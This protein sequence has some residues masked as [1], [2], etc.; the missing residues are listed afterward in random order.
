MAIQPSPTENLRKMMAIQPSPTENLKKMI[1][2]QEK[3]RYFGIDDYLNKQF[4]QSLKTSIATGEFFENETESDLL[5]EENNEFH[6][7]NSD[8][9]NIIT[10]E[11]ELDQNS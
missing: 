3:S 9:D 4:R 2:Q 5:N 1:Y 10:D 6:D 11:N 8:E 7:T